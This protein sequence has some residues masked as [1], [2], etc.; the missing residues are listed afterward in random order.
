MR[1]FNT[2]KPAQGLLAVL[3]L[4]SLSGHAHY[5]EAQPT[6][7][8]PGDPIMSRHSFRR[9]RCYKGYASRHSFIPSFMSRRSFVRRRYIEARNGP[10]PPHVSPGTQTMSLQCNLWRHLLHKSSKP[11]THKVRDPTSNISSNTRRLLSA[12]KCIASLEPRP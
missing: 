3:C 7:C 4:P 11:A 9:R 10:S 6:Q 2:W 8:K 1:F 5:Q 12:D